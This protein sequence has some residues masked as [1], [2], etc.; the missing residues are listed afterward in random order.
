MEVNLSA[1]DIL[2]F[3]KFTFFD[4]HVYFFFDYLNLE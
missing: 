1:A 2:Y 4:L 3:L